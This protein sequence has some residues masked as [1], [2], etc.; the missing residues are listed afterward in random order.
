MQSAIA[1]LLFSVMCLQFASA[2]TPHE[3]ADEQSVTDAESSLLKAENENNK[4]LLAS[5]LA[6][7]FRALTPD[8]RTFDKSQVLQETAQRAAT[9]FPYRVEQSGMHLFVFGDTAVAAYT[10][11]YVGTEGEVAGKIR[12]QGFVDVFT[13]NV[14]GWKLRFTKAEPAEPQQ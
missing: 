7:D 10:K 13:K 12:K 5:L 14:S 3:N 11:Q 4:D 8:G 1:T 6:S 9:H 2:Q